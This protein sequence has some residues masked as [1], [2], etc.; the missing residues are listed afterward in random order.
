MAVEAGEM[1]LA[2]K[3]L[4]KCN[5]RRIKCGQ[6]AATH[7][8]ERSAQKVKIADIL[9][10]LLLSKDLVSLFNCLAIKIKC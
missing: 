2:R 10:P 4:E 6:I 9:F 7:E 1:S 3:D 5:R 8:K